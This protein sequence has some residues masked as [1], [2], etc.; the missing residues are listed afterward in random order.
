MGRDRYS[1]TQQQQK[2]V[3][4]WLYPVNRVKPQ[5][6]Y[7]SGL[8]SSHFT[9]QFSFQRCIYTV[10]TQVS[11]ACSHLFQLQLAYRDSTTQLHSMHLNSGNT[12]WKQITK[13]QLIR[14]RLPHLAASI[15]RV[16]STSAVW[17]DVVCIPFTPIVAMTACKFKPSTRSLY[18]AL[19]PA[20]SM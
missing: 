7:K 20:P 9:S 13:S 12:P 10:P 2:N 11:I 8:L 18:F 1:C 16:F 4:I 14:V 17:F 19:C 6:F 3:V 15:P 5:I